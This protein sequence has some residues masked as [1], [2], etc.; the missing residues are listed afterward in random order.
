MNS[1]PLKLKLYSYW[2]SSTSYRVR[3]ALNLKQIPYD[4]VP[5]NLLSGEHLEPAHLARNPTGGVPVLELPSGQLL[6]ESVAIMEWLDEAYPNL[7]AKLYPGTHEERAQIRRAVEAINSGI[8]PVQNLRVL[9]YLS[10]DQGVRSKWAAHWIR[11]GLMSFEQLLPKNKTKY[12]FGSAP[13]AADVC[14]LPQLYSA[15]RYQINVEHEFPRLH[16][17]A[18]NALATAECQRA[19]PENQPDAVK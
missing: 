5:V 18:K 4:Y 12:C 9:K 10:D 11:V 8:H 2:R 6:S 13:T 17:I 15:N 1:Q 3:W 19:I 14:L 7:G 16:E